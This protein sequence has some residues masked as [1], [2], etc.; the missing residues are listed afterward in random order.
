MPTITERCNLGD[1]MY[2]L[3]EEQYDFMEEH[4]R[5]YDK[6]NIIDV[7]TEWKKKFL[8]DDRY[9]ED[10]SYEW[11]MEFLEENFV[12]IPHKVLRNCLKNEVLHLVRTKLKDQIVEHIE[13][14]EAYKAPL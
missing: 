11:F 14:E 3:Y 9:D 12:V 6:D 4:N 10:K 1:F 5:H 13:I 8:T 7:L 2:A